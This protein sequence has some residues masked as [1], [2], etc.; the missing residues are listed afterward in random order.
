MINQR[1]RGN[2][3]TIEYATGWGNYTYKGKGMQLWQIQF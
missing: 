1:L 3:I 2:T